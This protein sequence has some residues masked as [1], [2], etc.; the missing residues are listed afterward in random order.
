MKKLIF[1]TTLELLGIQLLFSVVSMIFS[2]FFSW[3]NNWAFIYSILTAWLF[4]G[5]VHSTFWQMG[6]RDYKN[7]VIANN[8]LTDGQSSIPFN[9][10]RGAAVGSIFF[11]LNLLLV[12]LTLLL[13]SGSDGNGG[14]LFLVHRLMLGTMFGFIPNN[15]WYWPV[16]FLLCLAMYLP[17][18]TA[19]IS[20]SANFSLTEKIVPRLLYKSSNKKD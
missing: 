13:D 18:I 1:K 2:T 10:L 9:R 3:M 11:L 17:C 14:V 15:S 5:A 12:V 4:L 8:H 19:Y 20:G 6:N 16:S 7:N